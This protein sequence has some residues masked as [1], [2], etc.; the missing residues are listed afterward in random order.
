M[1]IRLKGLVVGENR[2]GDGNKI[3]AFLTGEKGVIKAFVKNAKFAKGKNSC[4]A[5]LF[6]YSDLLIYSGKNGYVLNEAETTEVFPGLRKDI[7][8]LALAQYFCEVMLYMAPKE[9]KATDYLRLILNS[10]YYLEKEKREKTFIKSVFEMRTC[11]MAGY[12]PDLVG[13]RSCRAYKSGQMYFCF[14]E[15]FL[16]CKSCL[17]GNYSGYQYLPAGVSEALRYIVYSPLNKL[18][19]FEISKKSLLDLAKITEKYIILNSYT[20]FRALDF[21]KTLC[22]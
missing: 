10:L 8:K 11:A 2:A 14:A 12:M 16:M 19:S 18:F 21:Y 22:N 3:V 6:S 4:A 9:E 17:E 20:K 15:S 1:H 7:C 13:C 5:Q